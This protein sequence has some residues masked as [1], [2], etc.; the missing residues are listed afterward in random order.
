M[1]MSLTPPP[2]VTLLLVSTATIAA[3]MGAIKTT[4]VIIIIARIRM[5][6][7]TCGRPTVEL[8]FARSVCHQC[9]S[10]LF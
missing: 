4:P 5:E 10:L 9:S 1:K 2:P 3:A 7:T 8:I 6:T